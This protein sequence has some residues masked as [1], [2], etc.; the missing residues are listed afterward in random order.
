MN[1]EEQ[2]N[3]ETEGWIDKATC[4]YWHGAVRPT[5]PAI[6]RWTFI[7]TRVILPVSKHY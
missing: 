3:G 5:N 1:R 4:V 7:A 2:S 6:S